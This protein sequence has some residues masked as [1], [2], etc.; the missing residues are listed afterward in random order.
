MNF[1]GSFTL[2][3]AG[4]GVVLTSPTGDILKYV[5]QLYFPGTNNI[6]EYEGLLSGMRV[7]SA[8]R[9]KCLLAIGDSLLVINQVQ[10]EF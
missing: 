5:V 8:L 7:A 10:M 3:G 2:K 1:D 9:I 6:T 4:A